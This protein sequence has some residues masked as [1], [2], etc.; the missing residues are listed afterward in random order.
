MD[1]TSEAPAFISINTLEGALNK[2]S[3]YFFMQAP[4]YKLGTL[5]IAVMNVY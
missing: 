3:Y 5:Y 1:I 4:I 2:E